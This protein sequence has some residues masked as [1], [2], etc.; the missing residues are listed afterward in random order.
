MK[1]TIEIENNYTID[2]IRL[3]LKDAMWEFKITRCPED[4]YV[5][6]RYGYL[7]PE[8]ARAKVKDVQRR[9]GLASEISMAKVAVE[10]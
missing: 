9:V 4:E 5:A 8:K 6:E 3:L 1:I 7:V 10:E 2:E